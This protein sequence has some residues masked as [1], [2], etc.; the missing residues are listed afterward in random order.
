MWGLSLFLTPLCHVLELLGRYSN[1]ADAP[2]PVDTLERLLV[3]FD[4]TEDLLRINKV[5]H[6][7]H[8]H[9][10]DTPFLISLFFL[11]S[12]YTLLWILIYLME[13]P[14]TVNDVGG[15]LVA[16][17]GKQ[18]LLE[19]L[20]CLMQ[21]HTYRTQRIWQ[22]AI[23]LYMPLQELKTT[24]QLAKIDIFWCTIGFIITNRMKLFVKSLVNFALTEKWSHTESVW[25]HKATVKLRA[26]FTITVFALSC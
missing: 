10:L 2:V 17:L 23:Q 9:S 13:L 14:C 21:P 7:H 24:T 8:R 25:L 12:I 16:L 4:E 1:A 19:D 6:I 20:L 11:S 15:L 22:P 18:V 26:H 3:R 5:A